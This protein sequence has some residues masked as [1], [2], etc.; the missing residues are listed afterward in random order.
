MGYFVVHAKHLIV[1]QGIEAAGTL[2]TFSRRIILS[3]N[4]PW[5]WEC[6]GPA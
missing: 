1:V 6:F 2:I 5:F 3:H 4:Y